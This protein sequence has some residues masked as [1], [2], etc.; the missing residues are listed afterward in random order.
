M[1]VVI[2]NE[3]PDTRLSIPLSSVKEDTSD[4]CEFPKNKLWKLS[5][6]L[7]M[8]VG[9]HSVLKGSIRD[10]FMQLRELRSTIARSRPLVTKRTKV[11]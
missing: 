6:V 7:R 5:S 1:R 9:R 4:N 11:I 8:A 10:G 3:D 2:L